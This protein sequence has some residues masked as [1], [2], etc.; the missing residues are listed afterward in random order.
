MSKPLNGSVWLMLSSNMAREYCK[1][2]HR[3]FVFV[4]LDNFLIHNK[5]FNSN[6]IFNSVTFKW[7]THSHTYIHILIHF[8]FASGFCVEFVEDV[9]TIRKI[10][11]ADILRYIAD[12]WMRMQILQ[13]DEWEWVRVRMNVPPESWGE[14]DLLLFKR[15]GEEGKCCVL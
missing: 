12:R 15:W 13:I 2:Q 11:Y 3:L 8:V 14:R 10:M 9:L 7:W 1:S 5:Q 6:K 4:H